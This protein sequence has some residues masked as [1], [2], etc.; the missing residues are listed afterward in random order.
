MYRDW[1]TVPD[2][3]GFSGSIVADENDQVNFRRLV[4]TEYIPRLRLEP[5]DVASF[6]L[7]FLYRAGIDASRRMTART[8]RLN[9]ATAKFVDQHLTDDAAS[10]IARA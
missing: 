8:E 6:L 5:F 9:R 1:R 2:R 4:T 10:G 7:E 3:T